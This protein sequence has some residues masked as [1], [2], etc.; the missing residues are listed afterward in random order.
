MLLLDFRRRAHCP[1]SVSVN[2][3]I[4][5]S[6]FSRTDTEVAVAIGFPS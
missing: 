3:E 5:V 2:E 4:V 1:Q 6:E